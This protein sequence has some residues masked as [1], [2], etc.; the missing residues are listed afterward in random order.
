MTFTNVYQMPKP[1]QPGGVPV[2]VSGTVNPRAMQRLARFGTGWIPWGDDADDVVGGIARMRAAVADL[3]RDPADLQV[4][5]ALPVVHDDQRVP[6]LDRTMEAVPALLAAGVTDVRVRL[7]VPGDRAA[8][9]D[10]LGGVVTRFQ[11]AA[12]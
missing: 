4:V 10:Y 3:G 12:S 6:D 9:T 7:P 2:W 8:A 5:G 11:A 1:L